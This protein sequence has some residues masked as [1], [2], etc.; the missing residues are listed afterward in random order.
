MYHWYYSTALFICFVLFLFL[1][2][3]FITMIYDVKS[4]FDVNFFKKYKSILFLIIRSN[5][6]L[7]IIWENHDTE[8][9]IKNEDKISELVVVENE[10]LINNNDEIKEDLLSS[11][12][13]I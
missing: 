1:F 11:K 13:N 6:L 3:M 5:L 4:L 9:K 12:K 7:F 2:S 8:D 10:A